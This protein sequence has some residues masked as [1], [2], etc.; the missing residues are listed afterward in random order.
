VVVEF[1]SFPISGLRTYYFEELYTSKQHCIHS[2][3]FV[4][5]F[6]TVA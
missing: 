5:F 4:A 6:L 1:L 2:T 3:P